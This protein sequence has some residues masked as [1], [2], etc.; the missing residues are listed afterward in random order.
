MENVTIYK[1]KNTHVFIHKIESLTKT[2]IY[3][4]VSKKEEDKAEDWIAKIKWNG[5]WRKYRLETDAYTG[6]DEKCLK[7]IVNFL[8]K[9]NK[10][11]KE[12]IKV[13]K[14]DSDNSK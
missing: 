3:A 11:H 13:T 2:D 9:I 5:A 12:K 4:I 7:E 8:E 6:W 14:N 10:E 1:N